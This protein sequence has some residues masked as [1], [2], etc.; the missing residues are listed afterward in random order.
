[1]IYLNKPN[2]KKALVLVPILF[3][4]AITIVP[5]LVLAQGGASGPVGPGGASGPVSGG[6]PGGAGGGPNGTTIVVPDPL[7]CPSSATQSPIVCVLNRVITAIYW[8]AFP[9][10]TLM[11]LIGAFQILTAAGNPEK[12]KMGRNT[13]LYA[14]IGFAVVLFASGITSIIQSIL[15]GP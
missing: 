6:G 2:M 7:N 3:F 14:V 5:G 10:V 15:S 9:V 13:I 12:L 8:I 11:I 4:L 1:M